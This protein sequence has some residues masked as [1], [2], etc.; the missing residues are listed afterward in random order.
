MEA[1]LDGNPGQCD[2]PRLRDTHG[3]EAA[4]IGLALFGSAVRSYNPRAGSCLHQRT[5]N[6][7]PLRTE[8][9]CFR[10]NC[11]PFLRWTV[12]LAI[13]TCIVTVAGCRQTPIT[14]RR[15]LLNPLVPEKARRPA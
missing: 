15:Q 11:I 14:E 4:Y 3:V 5:L 10:P 1:K 13:T 7:F 6:S 9:M 12:M 2:D 8:L